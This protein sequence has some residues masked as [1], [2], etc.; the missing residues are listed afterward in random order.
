MNRLATQD[1]ETMK[2]DLAAALKLE[3]PSE[4]P[5]KRAVEF[6]VHGGCPRD[7]ATALVNE[8]GAHEVIRKGVFAKIG[9]ETEARERE[10]VSA[11]NN[12]TL[13]TPTAYARACKMGFEMDGCLE[14][15]TR[16]GVMEMTHPCYKG[17]LLIPFTFGRPRRSAKG[18]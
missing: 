11:A 18:L 2:T 17:F 6:L 13:K 7:V 5:A 4:L 9:H 15:G 10:Q 14:Y 12:K 3:K 16:A 1:A 8:Y